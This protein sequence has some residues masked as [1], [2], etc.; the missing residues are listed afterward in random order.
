MDD[1]IHVFHPRAAGLEVPCHHNLNV[2]A[3]ASRFRVSS[4]FHGFVSINTACPLC[5]Q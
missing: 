5:Y 1:T 3:T 2:V 4:P